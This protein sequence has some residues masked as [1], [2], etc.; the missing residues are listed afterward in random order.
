MSKMEECPK[1][2]SQLTPDA[3]LGMCP[4]CLLQQGVDRIPKPGGNHAVVDG[5]FV[6]PTIE[7][8]NEIFH[9]S[10]F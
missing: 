5:K 6:P 2:G 8:L 10:N 7:R 9:N 4:V 3:P 1:C